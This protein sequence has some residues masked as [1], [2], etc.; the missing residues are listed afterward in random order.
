MVLGFQ[1]CIL[2][3]KE[4]H[5]FLALRARTETPQRTQRCCVQHR[6]TPGVE[7]ESMD[8]VPVWALRDKFAWPFE[9]NSP[10]PK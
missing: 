4:L 3:T 1:G 10:V 2:S 8:S 9:H 6:V 5:S 7:C